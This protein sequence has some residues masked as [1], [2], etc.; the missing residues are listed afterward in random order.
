ML[1]RK[2]AYQI[3]TLAASVTDAAAVNLNGIKTLST[4]G[5]STF[6]IKGK[7]VFSKKI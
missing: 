7:T 5:L 1:S 3:Q 4:N 6:P 2:E